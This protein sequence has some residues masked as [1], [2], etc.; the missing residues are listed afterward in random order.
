[1]AVAG[2]MCVKAAGIYVVARLRVPTTAKPSTA[3]PSSRRAASSPSCSTP[4]RPAAGIFDA[5]TNAILTATVILSM[6]LTPFAVIAVRKLTPPPEQ[7]LDGIEEADGLEGSVLMIGFGRFAQVV[8]Q[9]LLARGFDVSII[10][11]DTD[12]IRS[13]AEFGFKVY[14]G[15]G[16]RLDILKTSGA[17]TAEA[18]IVCVDDQDAASRI[19][20]LCKAEFPLTKLFVRAFD[21][22][23]ALNL[24]RKGVDYQIRET[25][26]SAM[27]MGE[28]ALV[29]LGVPPEEAAAIAAD[30][31]AR[32]EERLELQIAGGLYAGRSLL[33]GNVP[34]PTPLT[35]PRRAGQVMS[36]ETGEAAPDL[37]PEE[38]GTTP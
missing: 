15:D 37:L 31:R 21:R 17:E 8:S 13:A 1:M 32:D 12:M 36:G 3:P 4:P 20:D 30:V 27:A 24:I 19:V 11:R 22:G 23:H 2:Y 38:A 25:L 5:E 9:S 14:Y 35:T 18:I 28:A 29:E 34:V 6:A 16:T 26:E 33:R 10:E 7:S